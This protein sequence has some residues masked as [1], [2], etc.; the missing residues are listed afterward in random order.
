M[1][2]FLRC[3]HFFWVFASDLYGFFI[4]LLN[5]PFIYCLKLYALYSIP[6]NRI[7]PILILLYCYLFYS[8]EWNAFQLICMRSAVNVNGSLVQN[9]LSRIAEWD[10]ELYYI[11]SSDTRNEK[12]KKIM[13]FF[14]WSFHHWSSYSYYQN[15]FITLK[16]LYLSTVLYAL[17]KFM[18]FECVYRKRHISFK[19]IQRKTSNSQPHQ[20]EK[21][22][23]QVAARFWIFDFFFT[24]GFVMN[25][26][27]KVLFKSHNLLNA[28]EVQKREIKIHFNWNIIRDLRKVKFMWM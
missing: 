28:L 27:H 20:R 18:R 25:D 2:L 11:L 1:L 7:D 17:V 6:Y 12:R 21:I 13:H 15:Y 10:S 19:W 16:H 9:L 24:F 5:T 23:L 22:C 8:K 3:S 14:I 4:V 26:W